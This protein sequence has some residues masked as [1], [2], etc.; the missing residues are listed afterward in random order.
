MRRSV[1]F[2]QRNRIP[3]IVGVSLLMLVVARLVLVGSGF[4]EPT[5]VDPIASLSISVDDI[6]GTIQL[7]FD[8]MLGWTVVTDSRVPG[9]SFY[10]SDD[11][12]IAQ[13]EGGQYLLSLPPSLVIAPGVSLAPASLAA[14]L[15]RGPR[16]CTRASAA[17]VGFIGYFF[18][19]EKSELGDGFGVR[20]RTTFVDQTGHCPTRVV[21]ST[22]GHLS[23]PDLRQA[24]PLE[25]LTPGEVRIVDSL[26]DDLG[27]YWALPT[28]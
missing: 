7:E 18:G 11:S 6:E 25:E 12:F 8:Q 15:D 23:L 26:M 5:S 2:V 28:P 14:S 13:S 24:V 20:G 9:W 27:S 22:L 17:E 4:H 21:D 1:S 10:A 16:E 3:V 19:V